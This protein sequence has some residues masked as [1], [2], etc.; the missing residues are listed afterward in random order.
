MRTGCKRRGKKIGGIKIKDLKRV[1]F[2]FGV[3]NKKKISRR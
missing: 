2:R 1:S 3:R